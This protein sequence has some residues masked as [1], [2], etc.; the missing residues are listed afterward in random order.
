MV[1]RP[2]SLDRTLTTGRFH[3]RELG[4]LRGRN[5]CRDR[6]GE[7]GTSSK[8]PR[9]IYL[10]LGVVPPTIAVERET[11]YSS[12]TQV[13]PPPNPSDTCRK[14]IQIIKRYSR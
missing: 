5:L 4:G 12:H 13:A 1:I 3:A 7:E 9:S 14:V 10:S 11:L 6:L 8:R 2:S